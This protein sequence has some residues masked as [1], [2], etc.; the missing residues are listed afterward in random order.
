MKRLSAYRS[1]GIIDGA[2][3]PLHRSFW[4]A[5]IL[6]VL[7]V[8]TPG[9]LLSALALDLTRPNDTPVLVQ[10]TRVIKLEGAHNFRDI[11]G[12]ETKDG[13]AVKWGQI[14]RSDKLSNLTDNDYTALSERHIQ[15]V[16][17]FRSDGERLTAQTDWRGEDVPKIQELSIGG[18]TADW[19]NRLAE[20]LGSGD[21]TGADIRATFLD[22]YRTIPLDNTEQ[23]RDMFDLLV[24]TTNLPVVIHCT[25]GKDRTGIGVALIL[26]ALGVPRHTIIADFLLTNEVIDLERA[27]PIVAAQFSRNRDEPLDPEDLK[28]LLGVELSYIEAYFTTIEEQYG[29]VDHYLRDG[30]DVTAEEQAILKAQLLQ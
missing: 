3:T 29:S 2:K 28:P 10:S 6:I 7:L 13:R 18:N 16:I 19:S 25:S 30:L 21:F 9:G 24:E 22:M 11:G 4:I 8:A 27:A 14:Y 23:Y 1:N 26:S 17:D 5:L 12:Y 20:Q 15:Q